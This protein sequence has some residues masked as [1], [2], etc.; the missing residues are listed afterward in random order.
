M[1]RFTGST[2]LLLTVLQ[3]VCPDIWFFRII[4]HGT[5]RSL[6][7]SLLADLVL[8]P[9]DAGEEQL[10]SDS[11]IIYALHPPRLVS[12]LAVLDM[13]FVDGEET[14]IPESM[15]TS[16]LQQRRHVQLTVLSMVIAPLLNRHCPV[17]FFDHAANVTVTDLTVSELP[18]DRTIEVD[19]ALG[20]LTFWLRHRCG[21]LWVRRC[22][23][24]CRCSQDVSMLTVFWHVFVA[25][26]R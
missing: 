15:R 1:L 12:L 14:N 26:L 19:A 2:Q 22:W 13:V 10:A 11:T 21:I 5:Q 4:R 9:V 6:L 8:G 20:L 3:R 7:S 24:V 18:E 23:C 25:A 16:L 17:T